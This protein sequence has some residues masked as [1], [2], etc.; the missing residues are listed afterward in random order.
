[1]RAAPLPAGIRPSLVDGLFYP[2]G[3]EACARR[4]DELLAGSAVPGGAGFAVVS[5]HAGYELAGDV[6]AA[7]FRSIS[8]RRVRTAVLIGPVHRDPTDAIFVPESTAFATPLGDVPVDAA[9][10]R[11]LL[12]SDPLFQ[13]NDIPHLEEHCLELQIPFLAR[14]F[15]GVSIVPM[16]VGNNRAATADTLSRSLRLTFAAA[17]DYTVFVVT[18]NMASYLVG[19]DPEAENALMEDLLG[20]CDARGMLAAAERR[21]LSACGV[22]GMAALLGLCGRGCSVQFLARGSSRGREE[23]PGKTVYY[24]AAGFSPGGRARE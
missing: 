20:R 4:V 2:A 22:A 8:L 14:L 3:R 19:R 17:G 24:A 15:P 18:A 7:A 10:V 23:E 1:M 5:P 11:S 12:D 21:Q 16:L 6:M 13:A 9:S